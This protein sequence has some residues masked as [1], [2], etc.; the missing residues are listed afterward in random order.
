ML[1]SNR[2]RQANLGRTLRLRAR[3]QKL[4][5]LLH[6]IKIGQVL[7]E[8]EHEALPVT[9]Y[10]G[11][12][13]GPDAGDPG[14][15]PPPNLSTS[16][17]L[18]PLPC[19]GEAFGLPVI[20]DI[21]QADTEADELVLAFERHRTE[22]KEVIQAWRSDAEA[23]LVNILLDDSSRSS[24][25]DMEGG[26]AVDGEVND[27]ESFSSADSVMDD[28]ASASN[29]LGDQPPL[30]LVSPNTRTLLRAD[31][32]FCFRGSQSSSPVPLF[33]PELFQTLQEK[34]TDEYY[35]N[36]N[37]DHG[38]PP[39]FSWKA[40]DVERYPEADA[41]PET[42]LQEIERPDATAFELEVLGKRFMCGRC[43]EKCPRGW[44]DM[45]SFLERLCECLVASNH[46]DCC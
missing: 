33:Y 44:A 26:T 18:A 15:H 10:V 5:S 7:L 36:N 34:A 23:E 45:V 17:L 27:Q 31:S 40:S 39:A 12:H 9:S 2:E 29:S 21:L 4:R 32:V 25:S 11:V 8:L 46:C 3:K 13:S 14:A 22:I 16:T 6:E 19:N 38:P 43:R 30:T 20:C 42:L 28:G 35:V 24:R 37:H 41:I 1:Q